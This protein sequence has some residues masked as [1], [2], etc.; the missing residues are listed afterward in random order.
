MLATPILRYDLTGKL[1]AGFAGDYEDV[2]SPEDGAYLGPRPV[3][4][5]VHLDLLDGLVVV[6]TDQ[7][8]Y[9]M[10]VEEWAYQV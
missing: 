1:W 9:L 2:Y 4:R 10:T 7:D 5:M 6:V 8:I 3:L